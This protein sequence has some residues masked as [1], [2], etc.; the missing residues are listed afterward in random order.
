[1]CA[2]SVWNPYHIQ[3]IK[4]LEQIQMRATKIPSSLKKANQ[5][6]SQ[7]LNLATLKL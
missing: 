7:I 2:Y 4:A 3:A 6:R 5:E 1:M